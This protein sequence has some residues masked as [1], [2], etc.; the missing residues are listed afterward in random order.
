MLLGIALGLAWW[1]KY[2][3][4]ILAAPLALFLLFDPDARR[5][6]AGPGPWIAAVVALAVVAPNLLWLLQHGSQPFGYAEARAA[7]PSGALD[8]LLH[9]VEFVG[10]Q[11]FFLIPALLIA[12][13]LFWPP[14]KPAPRSSIDAFD[15]RIVSAAGVRTGA[16]AVCVFTRQRPR[17]AGD[18]GLSAVAVLRALARLVRPGRARPR[19]ARSYRRAMGGG[20]FDLCRA[21]L[22]PIIWCCRISITATAPRS[23]PAIYS[24]PRS[25]NASSRRPEISP[26]TSSARCGTAA[27]WRTTPRSARSRAC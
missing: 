9:P 8:H 26:L 12:A 4:V 2:F 17:H 5:R 25:R 10:G 19:A 23:F 13:P 22:P 20:V 1:A 15:R 16:H 18:V 24:P 6:L 27:M 3:V 21:P 11:A 7:A 14:A